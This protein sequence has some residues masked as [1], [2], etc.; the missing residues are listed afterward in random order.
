METVP[1]TTRFPCLWGCPKTK[2]PCLLNF[3]DA[4]TFKAHIEQD[5][6]GSKKS[7]TQ[8]RTLQCRWVG[9]ARSEKVFDKRAHL[10]NH[11][12]SHFTFKSFECVQ[13]LTQFKWAHDLRKHVAK[14]HGGSV[15]DG[16]SA[17]KPPPKASAVKARKTS[18]SAQSKQINLVPHS[19]DAL[20]T[21]LSVSPS[22]APGSETVMNASSLLLM[23]S[24]LLTATSN[25]CSSSSFESAL[26]PPQESSQ[27]SALGEMGATQKQQPSFSTQ[28]NLCDI[29]ASTPSQ[30]SHYIPSDPFFGAFS[31]MSN[32]GPSPER[33][34]KL[35]PM[36]Y[37]AYCNFRQH[38]RLQEELFLEH[39]MLG[40][41]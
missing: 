36:Q 16:A 25:S 15:G 6:I 23:E 41:Q 14:V 35:N 40:Q 27:S 24:P 4:E 11:L 2:E 5:H 28:L 7:G 21:L 38:Q 3:D 37:Q 32:N 10:L 29:S 20:N 22:L 12:T 39:L 8:M 19:N 17:V 18:D 9:C 26:T 13:C 34:M 1:A 30:M 31:V 33:L